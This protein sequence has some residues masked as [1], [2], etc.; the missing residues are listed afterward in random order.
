MDGWLATL[1]ELDAGVGILENVMGFLRP[2][3][4]GKTPLEVFIAKVRELGLQRR[5]RLRVLLA[6]GET[7]G[8]MVRKRIYIV[9]VRMRYP[10]SS[11]ENIV[12]LYQD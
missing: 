3:A 2:D 10:E 7:F 1:S 4:S 12:I 11:I 6:D 8:V 9:F 5:Y